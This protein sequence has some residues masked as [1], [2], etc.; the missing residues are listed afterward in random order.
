MKTSEFPTHTD[1]LHNIKCPTLVMGGDMKIMGV[2]E[3]KGSMIIF[4]HIPNATLALFK[5]AF[6][7]LSTMK[8][9]IFNEMILDFLED[10]PMKQYEDVKIVNRSNS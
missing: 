2:D 10:K 3:R 5:D 1:Q 4:E 8:P 9:E 6:D 7:P